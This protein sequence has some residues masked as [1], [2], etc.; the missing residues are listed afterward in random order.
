MNFTVLQS[1]YKKDEPLF[2][3]QSLQSIAD[4]TLLPDCR[5]IL[6]AHDT[7]PHDT[8][9][10]YRKIF[11]KIYNLFD[12]IIVHSKNSKKDVIAVGNLSDEKVNVIPHGYLPT[13]K[14]TVEKQPGVITFS[15]IGNLLN[16]KGLDRL[17]NA[18]ISNPEILDANNCK[19]II[20]GK[21]NLPILE[22]I[23]ADKN[24]VLQNYFHTDEELAKV[25]CE[26]DVGVLPYRKISQSGVL[27]T[28]LAEHKAVIAADVGGLSQPF[29]IGNV[30]WL[31]ENCTEENLSKIISSIIK[32]P[33]LLNAIKN[34]SGMWEK[35]DKFYSWNDIGMKTYTLYK[36]LSLNKQE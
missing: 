6:T 26:S 36:S 17:V 7:L 15:F 4:N 2:L 3:S 12:G 23:P 29:D 13:K 22:K 11:S 25:V 1:V 27:L 8:G 21:G 18:W 5:I 34:D 24:I 14:V 9:D 10:K 16:Y 33:E 19:L 35:L 30:G 28:Y 32:N 31:L 20:A